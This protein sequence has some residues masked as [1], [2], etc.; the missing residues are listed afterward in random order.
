MRRLGHVRQV[1]H[2]L[3]AHAGKSSAVFLP[4]GFA[5]SV[6]SS[7]AMVERE[8]SFRNRTKKRKR[9]KQSVV[10]AL[11]AHLLLRR[12]LS[13][14]KQPL[15]TPLFLLEAAALA[16]AAVSVA[17]ARIYLGYHSWGQVGAGAALGAVAA[18]ATAAAVER[19]ARSGGGSGSKKKPKKN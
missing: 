4:L 7:I 10:F 9:K 6:F 8:I 18:A 12:R 13:P 15:S 14:P 11:L 17:W 16:C 1:R 2:A 19:G 3:V 5:L